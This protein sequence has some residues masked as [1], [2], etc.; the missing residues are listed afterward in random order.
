METKVSCCIHWQGKQKYQITNVGVKSNATK[1]TKLKIKYHNKFKIVLTNGNYKLFLGKTQIWNIHAAKITCMS[2]Q[3][4]KGLVD[5]QGREQQGWGPVWL[6]HQSRKLHSALSEIVSLVPII[7]IKECMTLKNDV[8]NSCFFP[9]KCNW[10][11]RWNRFSIWRSQNSVSWFGKKDWLAVF[12]TH[13]FL[14]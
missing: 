6:L 8:T 1:W 11:S 10:N 9:R 14:K 12:S 5:Y 4:G 7:V 13:F 3:R 2:Y